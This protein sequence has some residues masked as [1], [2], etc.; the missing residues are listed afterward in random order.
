MVIYGANDVPGSQLF[1][2]LQKTNFEATHFLVPI[3]A[4]CAVFKVFLTTASGDS[5]AER[6]TGESLPKGVLDKFQE[7]EINEG[8][9]T[10]ATCGSPC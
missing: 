9:S 6:E 1:S 3:E 10:I 7:C 4:S 2:E 5:C 8:C